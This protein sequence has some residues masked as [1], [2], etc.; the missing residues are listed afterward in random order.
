MKDSYA[1][2]PRCAQSAAAI[3]SFIVFGPVISALDDFRSVLGYCLIGSSVS[4]NIPH[5]ES[6]RR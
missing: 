5:I 4:L 2:L 3:E 6:I 1:V